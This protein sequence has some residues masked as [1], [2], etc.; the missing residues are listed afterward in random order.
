MPSAFLTAEWRWL[1]MANYA[2]D[3]ELLTPYLP[4]ATELDVWEGRCYLSLVG[5]LFRN[6]R[7]KGFRIPFHS[8]FEEVNLRTYVRYRAP[9]GSWR[10]GVVFL[11]EIVPL[12]T[13][14]FVANQAYQEHYRSMPM[15]HDVHQTDEAL[16][17]QYEWKSNTW[18]S[19]CL[20]TDLDSREQD[21]SGLDAFITEHY[22][23]YTRMDGRRTGEYRVEHPTWKIHAVQGFEIK[24]DFSDLYGPSFAFL[25]GRT[26][27]SL[28]LAEGSGISVGP[29]RVIKA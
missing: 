1:A 10:R 28:L 23:G 5:F 17:V 29:K 13:L 15:R 9:D 25:E 6:T 18:N 8:D 27:D 16:T 20:V 19:F 11:S 3:A 24:V 4:A 2:V 21:P 7:L 14:A 26:P 22:F 12:P